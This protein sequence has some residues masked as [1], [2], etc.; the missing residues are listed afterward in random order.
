[1]EGTPLFMKTTRVMTMLLLLSPISSVAQ[2]ADKPP[3]PFPA[4]LEMRVAFAPTGVPSGERA[5]LFYELY[6]TN[7][8]STAVTVQRIE[9]LDASAPDGSPLS[10][11]E[12]AQLDKIL[13]SVGGSAGAVQIAGGATTIAYIGLSLPLTARMPEKLVHRVVLAGAEARGA[14][15]GTRTTE[16][17]I[18]GAPLG[19]S[20][21]LAADGPGN[22]PDNHH[23][24]GVFV[25]NGRPSISRRFATD[26]KG[27]EG[28]ATAG[29]PKDRA[30]YYAY[31]KKVLAVADARVVAATDDIPENIPGHGKDFRPAVPITMDTLSGNTVVLDLGDGQYAHYLH[32]QTGSLRVRSGDRVRRGQIIGLVGCSGDAREPHLHFEVTNSS[33]AVAGEGL[34]FVFAAYRAQTGSDPGPRRRSMPL[35]NEVVDFGGSASASTK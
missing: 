27:D 4:Q 18:L 29:D 17:K 32:L 8:R 9:V 13:Q 6:L 3:T 7:F 28:T 16:L 35:N 1:M 15:I 24:R 21:W 30:S 10:A 23:R 34:P 19:G 5:Y 25:M 33:K 14:E 26:W 22:E 2:V 20:H 31:G 11:I 12:G